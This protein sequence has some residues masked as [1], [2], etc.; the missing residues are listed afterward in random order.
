MVWDVLFED[1][2]GTGLL[3]TFVF[4]LPADQAVTDLS[5]ATGTFYEAKA[6]GTMVETYPLILT[7]DNISSAPG[8]GNLM[9]SRENIVAEFLRKLRYYDVE[10][11]SNVIEKLGLEEKGYTIQ[12]LDQQVMRVEKLL[13][14]MTASGCL[15]FG[16]VADG[17]L[18][19]Q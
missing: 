15:F 14:N 13:A 16:L 11:L 7:G 6:A 18:L 1:A 12:S 5:T 10:I 9:F 17:Y 8:A 3:T 19:V 2:G 4:G